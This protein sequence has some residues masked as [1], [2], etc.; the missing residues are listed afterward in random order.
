MGDEAE[1]M[2]RE[3]EALLAAYRTR[4]LWFL[5]LD[6]VPVTTQEKLRVLG[7]VEQHGDL[8]AFRRAAPIRSWLSQNSKD[9]FV[10]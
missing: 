9:A 8:E 3:F 5:R 7:Y 2:Q 10:R 1:Q 4:C 6:Y